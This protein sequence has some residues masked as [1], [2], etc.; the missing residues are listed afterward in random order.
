MPRA[1]RASPTLPFSSP[2][3]SR[4][5]L[6]VHTM[7]VTHVRCILLSSSS[8]RSSAFQNEMP[9]VRRTG[10]Q[11]HRCNATRCVVQGA[12]VF[13]TLPLLLPPSL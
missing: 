2:V 4:S 9:P 8:L 13:S 12:S 7:A 10:A 11:D 3:T 5:P 1:A 6:A